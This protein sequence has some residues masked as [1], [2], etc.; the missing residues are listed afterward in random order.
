MNTKSLG[1]LPALLLAGCVSL[2]APDVPPALQP[3]ANEALAMIVAAKGVQIYECRARKE[4]AAGHEWAFV[5]PEAALFDSRGSPMGRHYA[6]PHW[7]ATDGSRMLGSV[8]QRADS[9]RA[10]AIPWLL[11]DA[12]PVGPNGL[13]SP[14]TSIQ[15]VNTS[16]GVAPAS[17]CALE[18]SGAAA[19]VAYTAD[20]YFYR[21]KP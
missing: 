2:T 21:S 19:R 15:R 13:F 14:V 4:P 12:K 6:G 18:T 7:E 5:A 1:A 8:K 17:S 16:G 3:A 11:L 20:Y 9:P 10:S